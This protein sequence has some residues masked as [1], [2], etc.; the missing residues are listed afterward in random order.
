MNFNHYSHYLSSIGHYKQTHSVTQ[1]HEKNFLTSTSTTHSP[2]A[3]AAPAIT[4]N[5]TCVRTKKMTAVKAL[6]EINERMKIA[7]M[8]SLGTLMTMAMILMKMM[9]VIVHKKAA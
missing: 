8:S 3:S 6:M 7:K 2:M 9:M 4:Y 5:I 1:F